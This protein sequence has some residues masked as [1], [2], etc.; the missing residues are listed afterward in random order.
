MIRRLR[1]IGGARAAWALAMLSILAGA[2]L[3]ETVIA[4]ESGRGR[5]LK[6][7][8]AHTWRAIGRVNIG[9][10]RTRS[11]C[12]GTLIAPDIVLTA[13][14]CVVHQRTGVPHRLAS[15]HFVAGW[16]KGEMSGHSTAVAISVHPFYRPNRDDNA[17]ALTTDIALIRL[18]DP[19]SPD[20]AEP[21]EVAAPPP[22]GSPILVISYR[23][24]RPNA[25]TYQDDCSF[26]AQQGPTLVLGCP[27]ASGAS[28]SPVL[29][30][31]DGEERVIGTLIAMNDQ[32][33]AFAI[34]AKGIVENLLQSLN[35]PRASQA[36]H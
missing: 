21:F 6:G 16:L 19:L 24:D 10:L 26:Q 2:I 28:G 14:H 30:E 29:A 33:L 13:A 8:E 11:L 20:A 25:L 4:A 23:R 35:N 22:P 15:I 5:G 36:S 1:R 12:T 31:I 3:V 34:Q 17:L 7:D 18:R 27:I 9:G 32:G